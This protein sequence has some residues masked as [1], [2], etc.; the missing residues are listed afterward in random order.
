MKTDL[1]LQHDVSEELQWEPSVHANE[2]GVE[3]SDGAVTLSGGVHNFAK[4]W[5]AERGQHDSLRFCCAGLSPATSCRFASAHP[6]FDSLSW[7]F[8]AQKNTKFA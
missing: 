2:I 5:N 1:Q 4:K 8:S 7:T 3:V 6:Q